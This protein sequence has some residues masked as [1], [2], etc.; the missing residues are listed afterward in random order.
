MLE[1]YIFLKTKYLITAMV[2]SI[3]SQE[4]IL[5]KM[6]DFLYLGLFKLILPSCL[7]AGRAFGM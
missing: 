2:C 7:M 1:E 4:G 6:T 3:A 5:L